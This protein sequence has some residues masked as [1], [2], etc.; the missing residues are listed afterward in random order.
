MFQNRVDD[1]LDVLV[2][3]YEEHLKEHFTDAERSLMPNFC[4]ARELPSLLTLARANDARGL[5][6]RS[7][8]LA[9]TEEML[10]DIEEYKA[11]SQRALADILC[12]EREWQPQIS[13]ELKAIPAADILQRYCAYFRCTWRC[14]AVVDGCEYLTYEQLHAHWRAAHSNASWLK[15][16]DTYDRVTVAAFW[17]FF[18]PSVGRNVLEAVGIPLDTPRVV[19]DGWVKEGR[20]FCACE[21]P[22]MAPPAEMDWGKLVSARGRLMVF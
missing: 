6:P 21:H 5:L 18:L 12:T 1:R 7:A 15:E 22:G 17:P 14:H 2:S 8:F 10:A 20:L 16:D 19:L 4:D 11:R 13:E 3:W 9:V